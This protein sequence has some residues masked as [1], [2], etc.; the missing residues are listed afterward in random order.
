MAIQ[1]K[2]KAPHLL[3]LLRRRRQRLAWALAWSR[4]KARPEVYISTVSTLFSW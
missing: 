4:L 1:E 2:E 3:L